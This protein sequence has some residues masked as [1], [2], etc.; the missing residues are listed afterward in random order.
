MTGKIQ[1]SES[2]PNE[3]VKHLLS[4]ICIEITCIGI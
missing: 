1:D 2:D 3:I 4:Q